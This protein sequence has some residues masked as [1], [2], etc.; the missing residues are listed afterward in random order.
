M[1][2]G[3][4]RHCTDMEIERQ[5]VDSHGQS[6]V[7]AAYSDAQGVT[8]AFNLNLLARANRELGADFDLAQFAHS[9][10]LQRAV[11]AHR[12]APDEPGAPGGACVRLALHV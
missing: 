1:M 5:Y 11:Q 6:E 3:V 7:H 2:E 12:D 4:L 10:F 9:A 8:A